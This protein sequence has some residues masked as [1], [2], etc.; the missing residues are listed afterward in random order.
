[1]SRLHLFVTLLFG[2]VWV[3]PL[4][5]VT[6]RPFFQA[7][8]SQPYH[9]SVGAVL[10][11]QEGKVACHYFSSIMGVQDVYILM[12]ESVEDG[13]SLLETAERGLREEFG[14][15]GRPVG[16]LGALSGYLEDP[17]L[18]FEK[19]TL[20]VAYE[21]IDWDPDLRDQDDPEACSTILWLD[22]EELI[23][24]MR[25]QG[26]RFQR[27]DADESRIIQ[28]ALPLMQA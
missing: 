7:S 6:P 17:R 21:L 11:N 20:Y 3:M 22:P 18:P 16:F 12:R 26:E 13:E 24:I 19:T 27:V 23:E 5:G 28:R 8:P 9:L 10:F 4:F 25:K 15:S 1:M 14:A 2:S